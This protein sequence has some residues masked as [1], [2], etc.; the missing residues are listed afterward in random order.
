MKI[1]VVLLFIAFLNLCYA[2]TVSCQASGKS[3]FQEGGDKL[4]AEALFLFEESY[5]GEIRVL[6]DVIGE[7][8]TAYDSLDDDYIY[9]GRFQMDAIKENPKYRPIKYKGFSQFKDF[10]AADT[11]GS[12]ESGMW[13]YFLLEKNTNKEKFEAYYIFQ[14]GDHMGGTLKMSCQYI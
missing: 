3:V 9:F 13:G 4:P 2:A 11:K 7:F 12:C 5:Q 1:T 14:A 8:K 6:S 10:D